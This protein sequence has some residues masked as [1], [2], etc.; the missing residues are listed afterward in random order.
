MKTMMRTKSSFAVKSNASLKDHRTYL[1]V[2]IEPLI[3]DML[4][5]IMIE[6]PHDVKRYSIHLFQF[7]RNEIYKHKFYSK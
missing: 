3:S 4:T 7:I 5:E 2:Y 6:C 1:S